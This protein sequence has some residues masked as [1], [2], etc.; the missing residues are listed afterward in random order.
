MCCF[1]QLD[2]DIKNL[3]SVTHMILRFMDICTDGSS[4]NRGIGYN[5]GQIGGCIF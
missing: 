5:M 1:C 2:L 4:L 3:V